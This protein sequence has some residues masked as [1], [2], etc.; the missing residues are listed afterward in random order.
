MDIL[1]TANVLALSRL[2]L[3]PKSF[4]SVEPFVLLLL[5]LLATL[6]FAALGRSTRKA[7]K[8]PRAHDGWP[9]VGNI[10]SYSRDPLSYLRKAIA[11]HGPVFEMNMIFTG[12]LWLRGTDLNKAYFETKEVSLSGVHRLPLC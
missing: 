8:V 9:I 3:L 6:L 1:P 2:F 12:T 5:L 4:P 11:Q 10:L 7:E